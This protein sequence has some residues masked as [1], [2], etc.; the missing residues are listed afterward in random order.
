MFK[1][2]DK[3]QKRTVQSLSGLSSQLLDESLSNIY[4]VKE[5]DGDFSEPKV[6]QRTGKK[7]YLK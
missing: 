7:L 1:K 3:S 5:E 4:L 2:L 6:A